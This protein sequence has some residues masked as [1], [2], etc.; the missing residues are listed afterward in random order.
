[1]NA[2]L[3]MGDSLKS[4]GKGNLF[5]I[6]GEPDIE[7]LSEPDGRLRVRIRGVD[8]FHPQTGRSGATGRRARSLVRGH[9][10]RRD[11]FCVRHAYFRAND[12]YDSLKRTLKAE[13]DEEAWSRFA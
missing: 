12:P 6:F 3:H 1:M 13:I 7:L 5:V 4:T 8:V 10:L 2:E 9:G 11:S